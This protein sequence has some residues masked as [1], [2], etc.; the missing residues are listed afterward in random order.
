MENTFLK[1]YLS[2]TSVVV[3]LSHTQRISCVSNRKSKGRSEN[4]SYTNIYKISIQE[5]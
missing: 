4:E 1:Q 2:H 3:N 5:P